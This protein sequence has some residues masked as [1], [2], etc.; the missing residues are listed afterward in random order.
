MN[1]GRTVSVTKQLNGTVVLDADTTQKRGY[2]TDVSINPATG[3]VLALLFETPTGDEHALA[4]EN[5]LIHEEAKAVIALGDPVTDRAKLR[6]ML[7]KGVRA[8][9]EL[10]GSDAVTKDGR[11]LG[12]VTQVFL[13][14]D[15]M[16]AIY[17]ITSS[18]RQ[19]LF[20]GGLY[21]A[22]NAPCAF[23]RADARLIVPADAK[24]MKMNLSKLLLSLLLALSLVVIPALA[25]DGPQA[26][27]EKENPQLIGKRDINK[28]RKPANDYKCINCT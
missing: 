15:P 9:G 1:E 4:P 17:H 16:L 23:S 13:Q 5:F 19:R 21:L 18:I 28:R 8:E 11:R 10:T 12:R 24:M 22:G 26:H 2:V 20:G 3:T 27:K 14:T 25:N 6:K 7:E